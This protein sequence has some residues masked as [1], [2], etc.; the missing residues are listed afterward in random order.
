M[1]AVRE[2]FADWRDGMFDFMPDGGPVRAGLLVVCLYLLIALGVGVYWSFTPDHFDPA[3]KAAQYA[4]EEGGEV[5]TGSVTTAALMGVAET[6][7]DKPGGYLHNDRFPPGIW[8]DNMPNWEYGVLVQVRDLA[9]AMREV[10]SRS[11]SC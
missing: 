4:A 3:D 10:L 9:R 6:L 2:R 11:Q 5:V 1:N 8:L 7:L